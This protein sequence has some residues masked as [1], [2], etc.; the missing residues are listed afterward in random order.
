MIG[1]VG[2]LATLRSGT[3]ACETEGMA[4]VRLRID[5]VDIDP[6]VW[7][8]VEVAAELP[9]SELHRVI[10]AAMGW[11]DAH[12]HGFARGED[13]WRAIRQWVDGVDDSARQREE[14]TATLADLVSAPGDVAT[15]VYDFGDDWEHRLRVLVV[16][17]A[18]AA[19]PVLLDGAGACPPEDSGG[20][21]GYTDLLLTLR[22]L[23]EGGQ[24]DDWSAEA[25]E[26]TF[27][28]VDPEAIAWRVE[29][30]DLA[31][32]ASRVEVAC[33]PLP[34]LRPDVG[35]LVAQSLA[36]GSEAVSELVRQARLA[37]AP[38]LDEQSCAELTTHLRW[39]LG[40]LG[41]GLRLT[42]AGYLRPADTEAVAARLG[43]DKEW[44][45]ALNR[46]AHTA[47]VLDF[48]MAVQGLRLARR[49]KGALVPVKA[50]AALVD[51][52]VRLAA[53]VASR[54]PLGS[55]DFAR[56][57]G[58]LVML[59][60]AGQPVA[61]HQESFGEVD[62][63]DEQEMAERRAAW[64]ESEGVERERDVRIEQALAALGWTANGR[65]ISG[66]EAVYQH[67]RA[68]LT[69]L[70]RCGV[71]ARGPLRFQWAPTAVGR[72]FLAQAL[73]QEG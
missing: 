19:T 38:G 11:E 70:E 16:E 30:F 49:V 1:R 68:T 72:A 8:E 4:S 45:G 2:V 31:E 39:F 69:V 56:V 46:E 17:D 42:S 54:L 14:A 44:F 12:L 5:L 18:G 15:Y 9:L 28:T 48:R 13:Y 34:P 35:E 73:R 7:R 41:E 43:V 67:A 25:L 40:H 62:R 66:S 63:D 47:P 33:A 32:A 24:L 22:E 27:G 64:T 3:A 61:E 37:E 59:D 58:L 55:T 52:P 60:L 10:Q 65:P 57:A 21:P 6:A 20:A 23:R 50:T 71:L 26:L 36:R 29:R 53:L 51:D